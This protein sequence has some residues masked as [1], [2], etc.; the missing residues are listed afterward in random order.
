MNPEHRHL[1]EFLGFR[2]SQDSPLF[3]ALAVE[4]GYI[5][6]AQRDEC[7]AEQKNDADGVRLGKRLL[8]RG[9]LTFDQLQEI[10]DLQRRF[11]TWCDECKTLHAA[12]APE[13]SV[14]HDHQIGRYRLVREAGRGGM[15]IVYEAEDPAL[16]RTVALK[17][18]RSE[19]SG[20]EEISRL[21]REAAVAARLRHDHIIVVHDVG[22]T[23]DTSGRSVHY[24]AMDFVRGHTM[25]TRS[26]DLKTTVR[27]LEEIARAVHYAHE[28]GVLHRDLKPEN[29]LVDDR[30]RPILTDFGLAKIT[31]VEPSKFTRTGVV[32]GTPSYMAPE[33]A[34]GRGDEL[35]ARTDVYSM[36]VML[37]QFAV[38][39]LPFSASNLMDLQRAI[40]EEEP[41]VPPTV[42]RSL[43]TIV[44]KCLEKN[45]ARR[46]AS[47]EALAD[48]LR[49]WLR[50]EPIAA[51]PLPW[52]IVLGRRA[53]K[54][55]RIT[56]ASL[57]GAVFA[58]Y[59]L[60]T[61]W[62]QQTN[63][64]R[65]LDEG[66]EALMAGQWETALR[67]FERAKALDPEHPEVEGRIQQASDRLRL[68][69]REL[70]ER[71]H[72]EQMHREIQEFNTKTGEELNT[73]RM[74]AYL[75]D[76]KLTEK[77]FEQYRNLIDRCKKF[78]DARA[79]NADGWW[80]IGRAHDILGDP[81]AAEAAYDR[82]LR[83]QPRHAGCLLY[84]S[85][86]LI[87]QAL[88][89]RFVTELRENMP[90]VVEAKMAEALRLLESIAPEEHDRS[91]EI[92]LA[93]GYERVV[94]N[95]DARKYCL[96]MLER[97]SGKPFCEEFHLIIGL[98]HSDELLSR[99]TLAI[100]SR[101][102]YFEA[103]HWR[104]VARM[105]KGDFA[106]AN[107]DF[108]KALELNPRFAPTFL[109]RG[110]ALRS[111]N[112]VDAALADFNRALEIYPRYLNA[113]LSLSSL[114]VQME[115]YDEAIQDCDRAMALE[116]GWSGPYN[117]RGVA[118]H[119]QGDFRGALEDYH[120]A[121]AISPNSRRYHNNRGLAHQALG[122]LDEALA[123][124]S[125]A[126]EL[127]P[128]HTEAR[129]NRGR[130]LLR[131]DRSREALADFDAAAAIDLACA[132]AYVGRGAIKFNAGDFKGAEE[133]FTRAIQADPKERDA[134]VNRGNARAMMNRFK[135]AEE[136]FTATLRLDPHYGP[137]YMRRAT[138]RHGQ[139]NI[140]GAVSDLDQYLRLNPQDL[141]GYMNRS[142][143]HQELGRWDKAKADLDQAIRLNPRLPESYLS[144]ARA[145]FSM[146]KPELLRAAE[147]DILKSLELAP[148]D[149][150]GRAEAQ[151]MLRKVQAGLRDEY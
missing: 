107:V 138:V 131:L 132:N 14:R 39:R 117:S 82:G 149:W 8:A 21:H 53:W 68:V 12:P 100:Q 74:Q 66:N 134:W 133:E 71:M 64:Q 145:I 143:A 86:I 6:P 28:Q 11:E 58:A 45:R 3:G 69:Q 83:L 93:R 4:R 15:G 113:H 32:M 110:H 25:A 130:L 44:R 80:M 19:D 56:L 29:V 87:Q 119:H 67:A 78:M 90:G 151:A 35:D 129:I 108:D 59:V 16:K 94:Q 102:G 111:L 1:G 42:D 40:V 24:I 150:T 37:F 65:W 147:S 79:P 95:L 57:L 124:F 72:R 18:L 84:K 122:R 36:G 127:E 148:A 140:E 120:R 20:P 144:R 146:K 61:Q 63:V 109:H 118:R 89:I 77:E 88:S 5:T 43:S 91:I 54:H 96:S 101:P 27:M 97:W 99:S 34:L 31:A 116:P 17:I 23:R 52:P 137:A 38:G 75:R 60:G 41:V 114:R 105:G 123:D 2:A 92:D 47:A 136:D 7:L 50:G 139:G 128:S 112:Q 126:A 51:R 22:E 98:A 13:S 26:F 106:G 104:G 103:Y 9:Y 81:Y 62:T 85:R 121:I 125:R 33:Q 10:L 142:V 76:W 30:G 115:K 73:L 55:R 70:E 141:Y 135:L 49:R 46:Y 48:D